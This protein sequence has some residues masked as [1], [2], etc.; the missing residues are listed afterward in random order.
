MRSLLFFVFTLCLFSTHIQHGI[1]ALLVLHL[2]FLFCFSEEAQC[3]NKMF[4]MRPSSENM[5]FFVFWLFFLFAPIRTPPP[6]HTHTHTHTH[7]HWPLNMLFSVLLCCCCC[8]LLCSPCA[9]FPHTNNKVYLLFLFCLAFL[10]LLS[11]EAQCYNKMFLMRPTLKIYW[12]F[13]WLF[14]LFAPTR[15]PPPNTPRQLGMKF[16]RSVPMLRAP[17]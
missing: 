2:L 4:L 8:S 12:F 5:L 10:V 9:C 3:C 14:F 6:P 1:F 13:C 15:N 17:I 11:E 7:T 16:V